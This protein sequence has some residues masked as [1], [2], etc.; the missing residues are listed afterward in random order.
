MVRMSHWRRKTLELLSNSYGLLILALLVLLKVD[1]NSTAALW[2]IEITKAVVDVIR[3]VRC[4][5]N[6]AVS[7]TS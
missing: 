4:R 5:S 6:E 2:S 7:N 1:T 3:A